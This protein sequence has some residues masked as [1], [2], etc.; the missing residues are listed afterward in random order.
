L[1]CAF[2][3]AFLNKVAIKLFLLRPLRV[4]IVQ[5]TDAVAVGAAA[6]ASG[7]DLAGVNII[8]LYCTMIAK[9]VTVSAPW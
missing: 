4:A 9:Y 7:I 8:H 3:S 5:V 2:A 6:V 1:S